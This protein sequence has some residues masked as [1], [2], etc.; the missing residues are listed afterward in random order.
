MVVIATDGVGEGNLGM[1][2]TF[3]C[4]DEAKVEASKALSALHQHDLPEPSVV[5]VM[6][7]T[8]SPYLPW[9]SFGFLYLDMT[10]LWGCFIHTIPTGLAMSI[11]ATPLL[12]H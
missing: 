5:V 10:T 2:T 6:R 12:H 3:C 1:V 8:N 4:H 7:F 9:G 11:L